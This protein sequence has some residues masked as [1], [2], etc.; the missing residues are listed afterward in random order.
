MKNLV[1][2]FQQK[3]VEPSKIYDLPYLGY[4]ASHFETAAIFEYNLMAIIKQAYKDNDINEKNNVSLLVGQDVAELIQILPG[5]VMY[6]SR[7]DIEDFIVFG[8]LDGMAIIVCGETVLNPETVLMVFNA[9][10]IDRETIGKLWIEVNV[11]DKNTTLSL[12]YFWETKGMSPHSV[13]IVSK[14]RRKDYEDK[15]LL[16]DYKELGSVEAINEVFDSMLRVIEPYNRLKDL[17]KYRLQEYEISGETH[18]EVLLNKE[19]FDEIQKVVDEDF[20]ELPLLPQAIKILRDNLKD[21]E[22]YYYGW[23]SNIA[24]AFQ[25]TYRWAQEKHKK[26]DIHKISNDAAKYFLDLLIKE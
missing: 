2:R 12:L 3:I 10:P 8:T 6:H 22:Q 15:K 9:T 25:D 1:K 17:L 19:Q 4:Y 21:D 14:E 23:Q 13:Q 24:M 16:E 7:L 18:Y 11:I 20:R 5:F 26:L